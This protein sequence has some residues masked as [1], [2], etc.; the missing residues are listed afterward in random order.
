MTGSLPGGSRTFSSDEEGEEDESG[1]QRTNRAALGSRENPGVGR[2]GAFVLGHFFMVVWP[3][4]PQT[5]K[6]S[7]QA[8][9]KRA[10]PLWCP[11]PG[12]IQFWNSPKGCTPPL[13]TTVHFLQPQ[14]KA[15]A[16]PAD[17]GRRWIRCTP[18][19]PASYAAGA[20]ERSSVIHLCGL[21]LRGPC[22]M[23]SGVSKD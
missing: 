22:G 11:D 21:T 3:E 8:H 2:D 6:I 1:P 10:H 19:R 17:K 18:A 9:P 16:T 14:G 4:V 20:G 13:L 23:R 7:T 15:R 12:F 5:L